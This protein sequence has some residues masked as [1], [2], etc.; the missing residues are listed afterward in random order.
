MKKSTHYSENVYV[1]HVHGIQSPPTSSKYRPNVTKK[2]IISTLYIIYVVFW[3]HNIGSESTVVDSGRRVRYRAH[4]PMNLRIEG[5]LPRVY[6]Y[7][8]EF[9][10]A[11]YFKKNCDFSDFQIFSKISRFSRFFYLSDLSDFRHKKN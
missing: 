1:Y 11:M 3:T 4:R 5:A 9:K 10:N 8:L 6:P 7:F 2:G